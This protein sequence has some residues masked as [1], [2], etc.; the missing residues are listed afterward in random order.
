MNIAQANQGPGVLKV[1]PY[2]FK[3]GKTLHDLS[4]HVTEVGDNI[5][6][7]IIYSADL[8][9]H[10]TIERLQEDFLGIFESITQ[11]PDILLT[12]IL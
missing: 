9:K 2:E 10:E 12:E 6:A 1:T 4:F 7:L 8:F 11:N 5:G 3:L